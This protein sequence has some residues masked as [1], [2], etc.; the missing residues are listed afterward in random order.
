MSMSIF[1]PVLVLEKDS[2]DVM[3]FNSAAEMQKQLER[4]DIE[5]EEYLAWDSS[6]RRIS[7]TVEEPLWLKLE[8]WK[9]KPDA[10]GLFNALQRFARLRGVTLETTD[11][12][13]SPISLYEKVVGQKPTL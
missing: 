3:R 8:S 2:G 1:F 13:T 6:G 9:Q 10:A 11:Q 12:D 4:I 7:M 5:N